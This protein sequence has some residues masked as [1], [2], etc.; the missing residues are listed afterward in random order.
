MY[1]TQKNLFA[2]DTLEYLEEKVE[3]LE[4]GGNFVIN[5]NFNNSLC[6]DNTFGSMDKLPVPVLGVFG[7]SSKQG[8]FNIQLDLR[9]RF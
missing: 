9:R 3:I 2:F 6:T 5:Y 8:K 4:R 7:T 1:Q